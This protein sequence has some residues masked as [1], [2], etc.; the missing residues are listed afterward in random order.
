MTIIGIAKIQDDECINC[1]VPIDEICE[2]CGCDCDN[3]G[4]RKGYEEYCPAGC[5]CGGFD[6]APVFAYDEAPD[7]DEELQLA[8]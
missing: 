7:E 4:G 2:R 5:K 1:G 6:N 8:A 3:Q